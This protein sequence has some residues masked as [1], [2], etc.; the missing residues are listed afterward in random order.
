MEKKLTSEMKIVHK[1][2]LALMDQEC[3]E[4]K[5]SMVSGRHVF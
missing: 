4:K 1:N 3:F 5:K 2:S